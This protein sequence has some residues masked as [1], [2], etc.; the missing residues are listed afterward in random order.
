M[1]NKDV[2]SE[3][4][5]APHLPLAVEINA[6]HLPRLQHTIRFK[7]HRLVKET[8]PEVV[9]PGQV[10]NVGLTLLQRITL[11]EQSLGTGKIDL[12][13]NIILYNV[14]LQHEWLLVA[15]TQYAV[16]VCAERVHDESCAWPSLTMRRNQS[17]QRAH[18]ETARHTGPMSYKNGRID[19]VRGFG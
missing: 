4:I 5:I 9:H 8:L 19:P 10:L 1:L 15:E 3:V 13:T 16:Q 11:T 2:Q 17:H 12:V 14:D 7:K 18:I 6:L